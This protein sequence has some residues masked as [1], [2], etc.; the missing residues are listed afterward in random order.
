MKITI[1][2]SNQ[3]R[4]INL[5]KEMSSSADS[6]F[7]ISEVKTIAPG[8]VSDF[9]N[10]SEVMQEYFENVIQSE[11]KIFG[12]VSFIPDNINT[13]AIKQGDLNILSEKQLAPSLSSDL[14]IV[15]G[16]SFI[17]GW[18]IDFLIKKMH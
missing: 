8:K 6:V 18:L 5:V 16:S 1:F 14:F 3:P 11:K 15:F 4:H 7:F 2:S 9:Y 17:K 13:L 12:D 10:K